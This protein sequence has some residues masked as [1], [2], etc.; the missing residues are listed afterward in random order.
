MKSCLKD[1]LLIAFPMTEDI[2]SSHLPSTI[3][4]VII[5]KQHGWKMKSHM[6]TPDLR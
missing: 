5:A 2:G 3:G 6:L 4:L 1:Q